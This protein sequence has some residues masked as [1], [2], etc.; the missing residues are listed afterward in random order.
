MALL[1]DKRRV[2]AHSEI[3]DKRPHGPDTRSLASLR[4]AAS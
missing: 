3:N 2:D 4:D 1:N